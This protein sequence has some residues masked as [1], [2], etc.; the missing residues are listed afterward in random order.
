MC[1][2][3]L[4]SHVQTYMNEAEVA[5]CLSVLS[6][7]LE[8]SCTY[9][10][11]CGFCPIQYPS[12]QSTLYTLR[13]TTGPGTNR[14][15]RVNRCCLRLSD[16]GSFCYIAVTSN[17]TSIMKTCC[18]DQI[19]LCWGDNAVETAVVEPCL[20]LALCPDVAFKGRASHCLTHT[21]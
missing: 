21:A 16:A 1:V 5:V 8:G 17:Y 15:Q 7:S 3:N 19:Q 11:R 4:C 9:S 18:E 6:L 12:G 2:P 13:A 20:F 10:F 14:Q